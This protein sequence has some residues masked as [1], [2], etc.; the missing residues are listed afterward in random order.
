MQIEALYE[1]YQQHPIICTDSRKVIPNAIF[2]ALKGDKFDG[3]QYAQKAIEEGAAFAVISDAAVKMDERYILVKDTLKTLQDLASYHRQ[4]FYVPIIAITGSNGKTTTKELMYA[5]LSC[6]YPTHATRGNFNNHIG[7]PLTL[8][9][10][11]KQTQVAIIEMG[12]NHLGEI[13][14]LCEIAAPT[15]GLIT[16]IGKAHMGNVGGIEGVKKAKSELY[17]YLMQKNNVIFINQDEKFLEALAVDNPRK[18]FYS[19]FADK[20]AHFLY[21]IELVAEHPFIEIA[22]YDDYKNKIRVKS[23]LVGTYNFNNIMTAV[24]VG[25]YFKVP[26]SKI[27]A[28]IEKYIPNNNRSQII[29]RASNTFILDAYNANPTSMKA[30]L[31]NFAYQKAKN[32]IAILGDMLELGEYSAHEH[33]DII[34]YANQLPIN[35]VILVGEEFKKVNETHLHFMTIKELKHWFEQQSFEQTAFLIKGSRGIQLE[36]LLAE[37]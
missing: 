19:R 5:V 21:Q 27:K 12:M 37:S 1:L 13:A 30:A 20:S 14:A 3:N 18:L 26:A 35:Q 7:V 24:V 28:A 15:H 8:L 33:L 25:Q 23:N 2:F 11:P 29:N 4:Q 36:Q 32:K 34:N 22:F 31:K 9:A 6:H 17:K 10:M 16:N